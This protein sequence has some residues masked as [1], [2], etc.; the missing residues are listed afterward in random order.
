MSC[1]KTPLSCSKFTVNHWWRYIWRTPTWHIN[2]N[3]F[4]SSWFC[5]VH[6]LYSCI[7]VAEDFVSPEHVKHCFRLTQEFRH[8]SNTHTNHEDKLQVFLYVLPN[9]MWLS[10]LEHKINFSAFMPDHLV[11]VLFTGEEHHLPCCEGCCGNTKSP[12]AQDRPL[13]VGEIW[14]WMRPVRSQNKLF[15]MERLSAFW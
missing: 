14:V 15:I 12:W 1:L 10:F 5:Q 11:F 7:K 9:L 6:N 13:L 4:S 3:L 8:L 2:T